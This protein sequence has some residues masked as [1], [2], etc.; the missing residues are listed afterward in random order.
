MSDNRA[1]LLSSKVDYILTFKLLSTKQD[2]SQSGGEFTWFK[3]S[4]KSRVKT[5]F[6]F[7]D[8]TSQEVHVV[9]S[10]SHRLQRKC[11]SLSA[12]GPFGSKRESEETTHLWRGRHSFRTHSFAMIHG[13]N[14]SA[15]RADP[16]GNEWGSLPKSSFMRL[17][18]ILVLRFKFRFIYIDFVSDEIVD[19]SVASETKSSS[20]RSSTYQSRSSWRSLPTRLSSGLARSRCYFYRELDSKSSGQLL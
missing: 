17:S 14:T 15:H 16:P 9:H 11:L 6:L 3:S 1:T 13:M 8:E 10:S 7:G 20:S 4:L 19:G 5:R 2:G 18:V 12:P